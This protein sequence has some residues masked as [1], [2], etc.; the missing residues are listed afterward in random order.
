M[1]DLSILVFSPVRRDQFAL[2]TPAIS[3]SAER[4]N[5]QSWPVVNSVFDSVFRLE[6]VVPIDP[7]I[8]HFD[9]LCSDWARFVS[10]TDLSHNSRGGHSHGYSSCCS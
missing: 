4:T 1:E 9:H 2:Q 5:A 8:G 10:A 6:R 7:D 3:E